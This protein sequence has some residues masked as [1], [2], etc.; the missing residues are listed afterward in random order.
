MVLVTL[1]R[2]CLDQVLLLLDDLLEGPAP[3]HPS[4]EMLLNFFITHLPAFHFLTHM[5]CLSLDCLK[6]VL[7]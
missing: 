3:L 2:L 1:C 4:L 7:D 5:A 6:L